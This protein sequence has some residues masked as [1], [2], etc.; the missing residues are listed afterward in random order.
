MRKQIEKAFA[1]DVSLTWKG[2]QGKL[3][4]GF[5]PSTNK[6]DP[7]VRQISREAG[8]NGSTR[9]NECDYDKF[10]EAAS[11]HGIT[12]ETIGGP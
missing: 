10:L 11:T 3:A 2:Y 9:I 5:Y 12:V 4:D 8:L 6:D 1:P 7:I